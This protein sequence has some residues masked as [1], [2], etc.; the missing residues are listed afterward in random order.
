MI[1]YLTHECKGYKTQGKVSRRRRLRSDHGPQSHMAPFFSHSLVSPRCHRFFG[2][3]TLATYLSS[4]SGIGL[5]TY[6]HL[7]SFSFVMLLIATSIQTLETGSS[8]GRQHWWRAWRLTRR[9]RPE[10]YCVLVC[11]FGYLV[12][13]KRRGCERG[14]GRDNGWLYETKPNYRDISSENFNIWNKNVD[15]PNP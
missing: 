2:H 15:Y 11:V 9:L 6:N 7:S 10:W 8:G 3:Q 13:F 14:Q 12:L 5:S 4:L 1:N